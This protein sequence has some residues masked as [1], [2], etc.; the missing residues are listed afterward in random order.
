MEGWYFSVVDVVG[1]LTEAAD[2]DVARNYWKVMK[3]RLK[4]EGIQLVTICNQLKMRSPKDGKNTIQMLPT[5]N[6]FYVLF[7]LFHHQKQNHL[8]FG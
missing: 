1:A 3:I 8:N 5:Q 2:Y 4:E 6:N 7:N